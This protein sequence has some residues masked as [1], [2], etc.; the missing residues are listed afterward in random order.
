MLEGT[1]VRSIKNAIEGRRLRA[2]RRHGKHLFLELE[3]DG[4][5]ALH[6][7]LTGGLTLFDGA[8]E[9]P[10]YIRMRVDLADGKSLAYTSLRMLGRICLTQSL[11]RFLAE[12]HVGI[13]ALDRKLDVGAF[14][15]IVAD[16]GRA[17]GGGSAIK[18]LLMDQSVLAGIGNVYSD[19]I[20]FQARVHPLTRVRKLT[21]AQAKALFRALKR[22]LKNSIDRRA[23]SVQ[24]MERLPRGY[25]LHQRGRGGHCPRCGT[26]LKT[27]KLSGRTGYYC[28]SCQK[29]K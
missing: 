13:D 19:E 28:P 5:L 6:F 18:A 26:D 9:E 10:D 23:G 14:E 22:V 4:W 15:G 29:L 16:R 12:R 21:S 25:L 2:C 27:F 17:R 1:S 11:R 3:G 8:D 20:L 24:F 7:G